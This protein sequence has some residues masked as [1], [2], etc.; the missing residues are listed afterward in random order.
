MLAKKNRLS[1]QQKRQRIKNRLSDTLTWSSEAQRAKP[2]NPQPNGFGKRGHPSSWAV[3]LITVSRQ[4]LTG[5]T[6]PRHQPTARPGRSGGRRLFT[7]ESARVHLR[8]PAMTGGGRR[9]LM[10][11]GQLRKIGEPPRQNT[12]GLGLK[13]TWKLFDELSNFRQRGCTQNYIFAFV[14]NNQHDNASFKISSQKVSK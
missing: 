5:Q 1:G 6:A 2:L 4:R 13:R 10:V 8:R 7:V 11:Q 14:I 3:S 12:T 9:V